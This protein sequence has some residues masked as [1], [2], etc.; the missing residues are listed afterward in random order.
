MI[1][2]LRAEEKDEAKKAQFEEAEEVFERMEEVLKKGSE[3][4]GFFGGDTIGFIDIGLGSFLSLIRVVEKMNGRKLLD[5]TKHPGLLQWAQNFAAHPAVNGLL[6][7]TDKLVQLV[8]GF[9]QTLRALE[10]A[11]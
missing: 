10:A 11:K 5:E 4:K 1:S 8:E 3:G 2:I 6:P 7:E 9:N